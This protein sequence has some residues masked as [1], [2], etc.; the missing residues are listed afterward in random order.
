LVTLKFWTAP[1]SSAL[2]LTPPGP[3]LFARIAD[4]HI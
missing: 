3:T 2:G 1:P 4:Y